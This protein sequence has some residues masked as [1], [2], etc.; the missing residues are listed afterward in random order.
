MGS[1]SRETELT[2][3]LRSH[4]FHEYSYRTHLLSIHTGNT[5]FETENMKVKKTAFPSRSSQIYRLVG[6]TEPCKLQAV[7]GHTMEA[8]ICGVIVTS[9][10][11][12]NQMKGSD[13]K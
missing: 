4:Q 2:A 6:E 5:I 9:A 8:D 13:F 3:L 11:W 12:R 7:T 1:E 10:A